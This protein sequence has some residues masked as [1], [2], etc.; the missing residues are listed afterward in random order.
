MPEIVVVGAAA[1]ALLALGLAVEG[2]RLFRRLMATI[3]AVILLATAVAYLTSKQAPTVSGARA[4]EPT[5]RPSQ[6]TVAQAKQT[7][8]KGPTPQTTCI[9]Q[10]T[11]PACNCVMQR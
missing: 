3:V 10:G 2:S 4:A 8:E 7:P 11:V 1:C 5:P 6:V 9:R